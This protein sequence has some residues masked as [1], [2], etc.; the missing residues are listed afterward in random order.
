VQNHGGLDVLV[1]AAGINQ[2]CPAIDYTAASFRKIFDV[3]VSGT[4]F[5]VQQA[6]K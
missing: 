5:C 4:F 1:T 6:A 2:V 3:N